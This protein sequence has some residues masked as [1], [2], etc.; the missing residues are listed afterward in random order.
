MLIYVLTHKES[1]RKYVG[2]T[3]GSLSA[4]VDKHLRSSSFIGNSLRK[5]GIEAFTVETIEECESETKAFEREIFW[6]DKLR[7]LHP[8]GFNL[9]SGG[10]GGKSFES[11]ELTRKALSLAGKGRI[12]S[13][14]TREKISNKKTKLTD[15]Q[16]E[17]VQTHVELTSKLAK[18]FNVSYSTIKRARKRRLN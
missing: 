10:C 13:K 11:H 17:Y 14:E 2:V 16:V 8:S 15:E 3:R 5:Y 7:A 1:G 4:R 18:K 12:F 9:S 6:I